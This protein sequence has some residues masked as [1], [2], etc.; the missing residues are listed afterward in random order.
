[1]VNITQKNIS[2]HLPELIKFGGENILDWGACEEIF[3]RFR[4]AHATAGKEGQPV[5]ANIYETM[6]A[7][8]MGNQ[9][10]YR[11]INYFNLLLG[12]L[13]AEMDAESKKK[14]KPTITSIFTAH[15]HKFLNFLGELMVLS[16]LLRSKIFLLSKVEVLI[17]NGKRIEFEL[18]NLNQGGRLD[19]LE[20]HNVHLDD[21]RVEANDNNLMK[22]FLK[23]RK[24]KE[25]ETKKDL[26]IPI[27]IQFMQVYWGGF[28]SMCIYAS[29]FKRHFHLLNGLEP[30]AFST[31][32]RASNPLD[33]VHN[34]GRIHKVFADHIA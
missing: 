26:T 1:M 16:I 11:F 18:V 6:L 12:A 7:V 21:D 30:L 28:E 20:V 13:N 27:D 32:Y 17:P 19:L 8:N 24:D 15:D 23:R 14:L 5:E 3:F 22:F 29:F 4:D 9:Q 2:L 10:A 25:D 33:C 34:Y 31:T